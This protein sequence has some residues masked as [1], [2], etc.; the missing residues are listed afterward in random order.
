MKTCVMP[1]FLPKMF[2]M[3]SSLYLQRI[4]SDH[5]KILQLDFDIDACRK[6]ELFECFERLDIR[7]ENVDKPFMRSL[8]EL[9]TRVFVLMH[10]A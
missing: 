3:C 10:A 8:F 7:V 5:P 6:I 9:F 4:V 2:F 1:T